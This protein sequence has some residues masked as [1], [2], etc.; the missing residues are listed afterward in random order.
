MKWKFADSDEGMTIFQAGKRMVDAIQFVRKNRSTNSYGLGLVVTGPNGQYGVENRELATGQLN[1]GKYHTLT[2]RSFVRWFVDDNI[3]TVVYHDSQRRSSAYVYNRQ[4]FI[5]RGSKPSKKTLRE[6]IRLMGDSWIAEVNTKHVLE[7]EVDYRAIAELGLHFVFAS[8]SQVIYY[9]KSCQRRNASAVVAS[10]SNMSTITSQ[11]VYPAIKYD[12]AT[13]EG[14]RFELFASLP[15]NVKNK[16]IGNLHLLMDIPRVAYTI[17][18][19]LSEYEE[20]KKLY[21]VLDALIEN[22]IC[23]HYGED[24]ID[25]E[26][27][28]YILL[29]EEDATLLLT[30]GVIDGVEN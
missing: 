10:L 6:V 22:Q 3:P 17:Y 27:Y 30:I 11:M 5:V 16:M 2:S 8:A 18:Y 14:K 25:N 21:Q 1:T 26:D 24:M 19:D 7:N 20:E 29:S 12:C 28:A 13:E 15:I 23:F 9:G 4:M